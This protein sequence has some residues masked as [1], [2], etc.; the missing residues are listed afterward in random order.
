MPSCVTFP[1]APCM[2]VPLSEQSSE[3]A[4]H[5]PLRGARSVGC[6]IKLFWSQRENA[7]AAK[8]E[9]PA[10]E[11]RKNCIRKHTYGLCEVVVYAKPEDPDDR[12]HVQEIGDHVKSQD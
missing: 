8:C 1:C 11:I 10:A 5:A 12:N 2:F 4:F 9:I 7:T 6:Q 3:S